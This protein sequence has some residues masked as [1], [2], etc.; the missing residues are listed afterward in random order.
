MKEN[1]RL[2]VK[3]FVIEKVDFKAYFTNKT[4]AKEKSVGIIRGCGKN[5]KMYAA[6]FEFTQ[7]T[8]L[9][10]SRDYPSSDPFPNRFYPS[11]P[12]WRKK[13]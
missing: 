12:V 2:F 7:K 13:K 6:K 10:S 11:T 4:K 1:H 8:T 5:E 9:N 3:R